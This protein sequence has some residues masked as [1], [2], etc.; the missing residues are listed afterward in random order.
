MKTQIDEKYHQ[1][2]GQAVGAAAGLA[3]PG[4][5]LP[6]LDTVGM[7]A[8]WTTMITAIAIKSEREISPSTV[9]KVVAASIS[10]VSAYRL[11]SK[12]LT[13]AALPLVAAAPVA[14]VP[15]VVALNVLLNGLFTLKLGVTIAKQLSR[16]GITTLD[17]ALIVKEL[18][19]LPS[20]DEIKLVKDM[21]KA[22]F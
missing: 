17:I 3:V 2:V 22:A 18:V 11:G 20:L 6:T 16:P 1:T 12:I 5:L 10:A 13:W 8:I 7:A 21:I 14:G 19:Q 15:A 9:T 4:V